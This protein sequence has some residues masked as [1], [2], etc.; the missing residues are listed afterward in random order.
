M[1]SFL[2]AKSFSIDDRRWTVGSERHD[3]SV[4]LRFDQPQ[5]VFFGVAG[6]SERAVTAG[7][8]VGDVRAGGSCNCAT[9]SITP[10]CNGTHTECVGHIT[11]E[12]LSVRSL[13]EQTLDVALVV[14]VAPV[15]ASATAE[16]SDPGPQSDD[17]LITRAS[18]EAAMASAAIATFTALVI[19]TLP[20]SPHKLTRD[21][22]R[23]PAPFFTA[24]AMR[25][26]VERGVRHLVV[27]LPSLD[28]ANDEGRLTAHRIFWNVPAGARAID[29]ATRR[30][31]TVTELAYIDDA[32]RDGPYLLN[33]QV[34][35]F[36]ADAAPSRPILLPLIPA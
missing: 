30:H 31:A 21:Y 11:G 2:E 3:L 12:R 1:N 35:P 13:C 6:A 36:E 32:V 24:E 17:W 16:S 27:D 18:L 14:S 8:F 7:S 15:R 25:F 4:P 23:E 33:L 28:R 19:R 34:A 10:H 22:D 26:I 9:F 5:P 20:N 29:A